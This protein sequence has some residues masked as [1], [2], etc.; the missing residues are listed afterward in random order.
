MKKSILLS[1]LIG[2]MGVI[3]LSGCEK[4]EIS[5]RKHI[6]GEWVCVNDLYNNDGE[7]KLIFKK[8]NVTVVN[9]ISH[10]SVFDDK[11]YSYD[12]KDDVLT[13]HCEDGRDLSF[14]FSLDNDSA[15]LT[16]QYHGLVFPSPGMPSEYYVLKKTNN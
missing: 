4:S 2:M 5:T 1:L 8:D 10:P 3:A 12:L 15:T 7:L 14:T 6:K 9:T 16:L 11:K 13:L